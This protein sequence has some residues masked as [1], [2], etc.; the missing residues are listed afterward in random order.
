VI[1]RPPGLRPDLSNRA[2]RQLVRGETLQEAK[3]L[4]AETKAAGRR[5]MGFK[6]AMQTPRTRAT[7]GALGPGGLR[8]Q[9]RPHVAAADPSTRAMVLATLARFFRRHKERM[10]D[11]RTG[12]RSTPFPAGTYQ[13]RVVHGASVEPTTV[14]WAVARPP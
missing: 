14:P 1:R 2:L 10:D 13:M 3:R 4:V 7:Q 9:F 12:D 6:R 11:W 8:A 5:F